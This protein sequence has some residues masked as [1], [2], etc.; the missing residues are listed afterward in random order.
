MALRRDA[1][2]GPEAT[3]ERGELLPIAR[4]LLAIA[5]DRCDP[6]SDAALEICAAWEAL[7]GAGSPSVMVEPV[8]PSAFGADVVAVMARRALR[9]AMVDPE[10]PASSALPTAVALR[11]LHVASRVLAEGAT[12]DGS[13]WD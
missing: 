3:S 10:L 13:P 7:A 5:L 12:C 2:T 8:V 6:G 1:G 9:S 4:G 11:R